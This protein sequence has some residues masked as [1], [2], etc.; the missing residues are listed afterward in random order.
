M[1][2]GTALL[3]LTMLPVLWLLPQFDAVTVILGPAL[4][5][6]A[7][8]TIAMG[9][10]FW[11]RS[12]YLRAPTPLQSD[13]MDGAM[14]VVLAVIVIGLMAALRP[15]MAQSLGMV[16]GWL[17]LAFIINFGM[18]MVC[19]VCFRRV[20][21]PRDH[22]PVSIV[23]G[24]RNIAIFLVA[25]SPATAEPLLIFLGCYQIPMYLTPLL[26]ARLYRKRRI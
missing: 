20:L 26:M 3:P 1:V 2:V 9:L 24:N 23:A 15:A 19:Y 22:V 13:A 7:A 4:R 11:V 21:R 6:L 16:A 12:T 5:A 17:L 10:G 25:L 18:Q 8:I 14:T